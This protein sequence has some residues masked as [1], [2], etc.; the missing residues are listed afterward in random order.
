MGFDPDT[1]WSLTPKDYDLRMKAG[2]R[3]KVEDH[4]ARAWQAWH[5]GMIAR[6]SKPPKLAD[7]MHDDRPTRRQTTEEMLAAAMSWHHVL[8]P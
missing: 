6:S 4:N 3:R 7:L 2:Q 8:N 1:F 5:A